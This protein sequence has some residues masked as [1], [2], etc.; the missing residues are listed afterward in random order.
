MQ[1]LTSVGIALTTGSTSSALEAELCLRRIA[2]AAR[3]G[4]AVAGL[5]PAAR[6]RPGAFLAPPVA[7]LPAG[8]ST[9]LGVPTGV[10]SIASIHAPT[11]AVPATIAAIRARPAAAA[12]CA[13]RPS[14]SGP[15][16][17]RHR[18]APSPA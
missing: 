13:P 7:D 9:R 12:S 11:L 16:L 6:L 1:P 5:R 4:T 18:T 10:Q 17:A 14:V 15:R 3:S 2:A 8:R